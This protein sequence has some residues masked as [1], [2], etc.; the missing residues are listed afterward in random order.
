MWMLVVVLG[1][2]IV[3]TFYYVFIYRVQQMARYGRLQLPCDETI[4]L[5]AGEVTVY[6]EDGERWKHN[7]RPEMGPGFRIRLSAESGEP[8]DMG[9]PLDGTPVKTSRHNRIPYGRIELP[10]PGR[11]R[12]RGEIGPGVHEPAVLFGRG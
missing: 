4:E 3:A 9:E 10:Q 1:I 6:Y 2:A 8:F 7:Q 12:V 5:P 11:F